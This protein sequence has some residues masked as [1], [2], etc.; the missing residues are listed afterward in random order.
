MRVTEGLMQVGDF[1]LGLRPETPQT[2]RQA[3]RIATRARSGY[4]ATFDTPTDSPTL[5]AALSVGWLTK[6]TGR[7]QFAGIDLAGVLQS[8]GNLGKHVTSNTAYA[9]Q[10]LSAWFDD[11]LPFGGITKGTVT[12]TGTSPA[13]TW[14]MGLGLREMIDYVCAQA[15]AVWRL[16]TDGTIDAAAPDTLFGT[17]PSVLVSDSETTEITSG[18]LSGIRGR[19][20]GI[21][22][23]SSQLAKRTI[24][25]GEGFGDDIEVA[26]T[27]SSGTIMVG[28]DGNSLQTD[29]PIDLQS[30]T[31]TEL[32]SLTAAA[33]ARFAEPRDAFAV[34][35]ETSGVRDRISPGDPIYVYDLDADVYG[36]DLVS[37]SGEAIRPLLVRVTGMTWETHRGQGVWLYLPADDAWTDLTP[38]MPQSDGPESAPFELTVTTDLGAG[39]IVKIIG[40]DRLGVQ[41]P[42]RPL[43]DLSA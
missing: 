37:F 22:E 4:V 13:L 17:S 40:P 7:Y 8:N 11:L 38:W 26:S 3:I 35:G 28:I 43:A 23:D 25:Y 2:I 6:R 39:D 42:D 16:N 14:P 19:V 1:T 30:S 15:G 5:D 21:L 29:R 34:F 24:G 33:A 36:D 18:S 12:N 10:T 32:T 20:G 27:T 41:R 9:A 31:G